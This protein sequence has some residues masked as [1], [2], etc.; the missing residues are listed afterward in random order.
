MEYIIIGLVIVCPISVFVSYK[1]GFKKASEAF[2]DMLFKF[3]YETKVKAFK[4]MNKTVKK[5]GIVFIGDSITQ[6]YNVYEYFKGYDVYNRGIGGDTTLGLLNRLDVSVFELN[7]KKVFIQMGTNDLEL[8]D[9]KAY[10]I[11][12]RMIEIVDKIKS[13]DQSIQIYMIS[14]YPVNQHIDKQTVGKRSNEEI[15]QTNALLKQIEGVSFINIYDKL[16]E[17]DVLNPAYTLEGLHLNQEGY[18]VVTKVLESY[19]KAS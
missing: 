13:F 16:L 12:E 8:L 6:D 4:I 11:Y 1:Y 7:P 2:F 5:G 19:V 18:Q 9:A 3:G 17:S 10:D 14:I 15:I